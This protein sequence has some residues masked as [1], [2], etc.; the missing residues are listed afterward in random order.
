MMDSANMQLPECFVCTDSVPVPRRSACL[1]TDRYVHDECLAK[2]LERTTHAACPV[3]MAPYTNV[4]S[5][6][7]LVGVEL[8][9]RGGIVIGA[10]AMSIILITC[11]SNTWWVF[12]H[13]DFSTRTDFVVCFAAIIMTIAGFTSIAIIGYGCVIE[14]PRALVMSMQ[15]RKR[16][17][18]VNA[19]I[20]TN[21]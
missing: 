1:C 8:R 10:V 12:G 15:V 9:S 6:V 14:G 20:S 2:M 16:K 21:L 7:V 3:C 17:V 4:A 5:R 11:A 19:E 13:S 18:R